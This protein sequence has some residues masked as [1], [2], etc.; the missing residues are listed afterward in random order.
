MSTDFLSV[1][2]K[3]KQSG[4]TVILCFPI[5]LHSHKENSNPVEKST[6]DFLD[7]TNVMTREELNEG[8]YICGISPFS[9]ETYK[10]PDHLCLLQELG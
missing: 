3:R 6:V 4:R 8:S 10:L 1:A 9:R 7:M 5:S 2:L